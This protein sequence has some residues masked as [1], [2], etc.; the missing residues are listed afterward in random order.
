MTERHGTDAF[1]F[2]AQGMAGVAAA[3][4][5]QRVRSLADA[6]PAGRLFTAI[7]TLTD[8]SRRAEANLVAANASLSS[9]DEA[10]AAREFTSAIVQLDK[11]EAAATGGTKQ[12][13]AASEAPVRSRR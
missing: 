11:L 10:T 12:S 4:A 2:A 8:M 13:S 6:A 9:G 7:A 5:L 1:S 3:A